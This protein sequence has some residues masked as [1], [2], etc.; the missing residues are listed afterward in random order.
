LFLWSGVEF[1]GISNPP[2]FLKIVSRDKI[3]KN[4]PHISNNFQIL[5]FKKPD[6]SLFI[7]PNYLNDSIL[8]KKKMILKKP[9]FSESFKIIF[10][11]LLFLPY[12]PTR[13]QHKTVFNN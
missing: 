5:I 2:P 13:K 3:T 12:L 6:N 11:D 1:S 7:F 4:K 8:Q 9:V 10:F